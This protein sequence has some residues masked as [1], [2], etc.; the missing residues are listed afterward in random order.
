ML[1]FGDIQISYLSLHQKFSGSTEGMT[2]NPM[3]WL[4]VP[5]MKRLYISTALK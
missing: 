5:H 2:P 3:H 1:T 4:E